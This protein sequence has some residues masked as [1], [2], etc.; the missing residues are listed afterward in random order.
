MFGSLTDAITGSGWAYAI[1]AA[2]AFLD[3]FFRWSQAKLR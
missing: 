3:S 1:I 2:I